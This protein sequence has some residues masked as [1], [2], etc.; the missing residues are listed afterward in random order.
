MGWS[1]RAAAVAIFDTAGRQEVDEELLEELKKS[2]RC[3]AA[4][5]DAARRGCGHRPAGGERGARRSTRR[6]AS[7]ASILTKLDGDARGGALLSMRQVTGCPV[8]FIGVGEKIEALEVFHPDRMAQR[9]LGMGDVVSASSRK[10]RRDRR[11][12]RRCAWPS[13]RMEA[14]FDFNDFLGQMKMHEET[15][16]AR[17]ACWA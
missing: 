4:E 7:P 14:K 3:R 15:R 8:K 12:G 16:A 11:E 5:R 1:S 10:P 9:I 13:A 17:R 2:A 6:S